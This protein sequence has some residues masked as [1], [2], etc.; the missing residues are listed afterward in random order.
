MHGLEPV[1]R[2]RLVGLRHLV[3]ILFPLDR[4]SGVVGRVKNLVRQLIRREETCHVKDIF[5]KEMYWQILYTITK[6]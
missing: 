2:E 5:R 1:V 4:G 3:H 6:W